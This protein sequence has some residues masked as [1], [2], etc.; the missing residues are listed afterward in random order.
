M[1]R[2]LINDKAIQVAKP[3][4]TDSK[5]NDGGGLF[6]LARKTGVKLWRYRYKMAGKENLFALGEYPLMSLAEARA[7]RDAS[8]EAWHSP[9][10]PS[11]S[12]KGREHRGDRSDEAQE[13]KHL[14]PRWPGLLRGKRNG[15]PEPTGPRVRGL[16]VSC[17]QSSG[18]RRWKN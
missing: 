7:A 13:R 3:G 9:G 15:R 18:T 16:I 14:P 4:D 12:R 5:T 1:A 6:P 2:Y 17:C 8:G 11:E 10:A